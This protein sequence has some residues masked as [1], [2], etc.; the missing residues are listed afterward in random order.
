MQVI[1]ENS[2]YQEAFIQSKIWIRYYFSVYDC[3]DCD[4]DD[5]EQDCALKFIELS[6]KYDPFH[7]FCM[8]KKVYKYVFLNRFKINERSRKKTI[9]YLENKIYNV[10]RFFN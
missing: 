4:Y 8:T 5:Y 10:N 2:S 3:K 7:L 9:S 1:D 6:N